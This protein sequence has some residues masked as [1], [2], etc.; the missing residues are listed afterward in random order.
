VLRRRA[1]D[2]RRMGREQARDLGLAFGPADSR[3]DGVAIW[4][5]DRFRGRRRYIRFS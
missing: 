5:L 4:D 2:L 1:G 3:G